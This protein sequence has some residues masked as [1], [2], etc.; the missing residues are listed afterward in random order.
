M[1]LR[2]GLVT[3]VVVSSPDAAREALQ[4]KDPDLASRSVP[5]AIQVPGHYEVSLI[6]NPHNQLWKNLRAIIK[7]H[8]F[9][10]RRLDATQG[11][12]RRKVEQLVGYV[13]C[14]AGQ[15]IDIGQAAFAT[16]L[17]V[18]TSTFFSV[19][20]VD[21]DSDGVGDFKDIVSAIMEEVGRPNLSD[22]FPLLR[23]IDPQGL[24]RRVTAHIGKVYKLF[25]QMI[26]SRLEVMLTNRKA[27][28]TRHD[29]LDE[30]VQLHIQENDT[31][32]DRQTIK[33]LLVDML[34][35]GSDTSSNTVQWA[36]AELLRNTSCMAKAQA[37]LAKEIG[38][39]REVEESDIAGLPFLQAVVKETLR[40]HPP[41]PLLLPHK[42]ETDVELGG[43]AVPKGTRVL[44]NAWAIGHDGDVWEDPESFKPERFLGSDVDFRGA[45]FEL[46]PFG[47]G[48]RL[49][50]GLPLAFRTV[51][52]MLASLLQ[53]FDWKLPEGMQPSDVD[54]TERFGV[55][56]ALA[57]PLRA[58]AVPT[59]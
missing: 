44:V 10:T 11:L 41:V 51:H 13:R 7:S 18:I 2:L 28:N 22:F 39:Q 15:A 25:D 29:F 42:A 4:K 55:T 35:A 1:S 37:E 24:R 54:I 30:L 27:N 52:L 56:L 21:L 40:L 3:T 59:E 19:D 38:Y 8:L 16:S 6:W 12:R 58:V 47:S 32:L 17:N 45:D 36:M 31:K 53:S 20:L 14:H 43:Y 57:A 46:I 9:T 48:R 23:V 5:D 50:P 34:L 49:C 26:D 33:T